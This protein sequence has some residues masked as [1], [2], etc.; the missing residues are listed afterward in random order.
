MNMG[1]RI[2]ELRKKKGIS[3]DL[4]QLEEKRED[5]ESLESEMTLSMEEIFSLLKENEE[6]TLKR[7]GKNMLFMAIG[8]GVIAAVVLAIIIFLYLFNNNISR[9]IQNMGT[10]NWQFIQVD[11][12]PT[13]QVTDQEK[14][15]ADY[16]SEIKMINPKAK[17][18]TLFMTAI[19]K[20]YTDNMQMNFMVVSEGS[21]PITVEGKLSVGQMFTCEAEFP[22]SD[23][24]KIYANI[25]QNE[26][27][28]NEFMEA[29]YNLTERYKLDIDSMWYSGQTQIKR[30]DEFTVN[31]GVTIGLYVTNDDNSPNS[32]ICWPVKG[33]VGCYEND[34]LVEELQIDIDPN[35]FSSPFDHMND[36]T[37]REYKIPIKG[38]FKGKREELTFKATIV[39]NF[40]VEYYS[41]CV[42]F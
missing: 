15:L 32:Y 36:T 9:Q 1:D 37:F 5:Q 39:D 7:E 11:P 31:G 20:V 10:A 18:I 33:V 26:E 14:V 27:S 41:E 13:S 24:I 23:D 42:M 2:Q 8:F 17:R 38:T 29:F 28:Q 4:L 25:L 40:G 3:Q 22:L 21:D 30:K 12:G 6:A 19:P 34:K 35:D 16:K